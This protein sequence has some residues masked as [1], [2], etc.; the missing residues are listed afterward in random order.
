MFRSIWS[1]SLR[2]YRVT[3]LAWGLGLGVLMAAGLAEATPTVIAAFANLATLF[4]FLGDPYAIQTPEGFIT[5]RWM[6]AFL[7]LLLSF[8]PI[9]VGARL[10]RGEEERGTLD[11]LLATPQTRTRLLLSK[12]GALASALILIAV[13]FALG[14]VAGEAR[15]G[16][17]HIAMLRALLAGL[18]LGLLAFFF[19]MVALLLSQLTISRGVAA[20]WTSGLLLLTLLLDSTG[21]LVNGSWVQYLSPFYYYNLNRPLIPSFPDQPVAVLLLLGLSLLCLGIS[22]VLFTRRDIG[23]A[24]FSWQRKQAFN[25]QQALHSLGRAERAFS[26]RNVSLHTLSE[27]GWP[28]FWWLFGVVVLCVYCLLLALYIQQPFDKLVQETPLLQ[29]LL[30]DTPTNTNTA[31]LGTF[32]F[33]FMPA[34]VAIFALVLALKWSEDLENGRLELIFSTPQSRIRVLLERFGANALVLL[35]APVLTWLAITIGAQLAHLSVDQGRALAASFNMLPMALITISLVYALAG[36]IRYNALLG[37]LVAY[38]VLSFV[39]ELLEG[40]IQFPAWLMSL[41]IF[42]LYGNPVFL[43]MNWNNFLGMTAVAA[44]LLLLGLVQFRSADIKLG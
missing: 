24:A 10:V 15:L 5:F 4:R 17:G 42:H 9:L 41:S 23:R 16:G 27:Q 34:L 36:R 38:L 14:T 25:N 1:K 7:P 40:M 43:G 20:G 35:P 26:T 6:G 29:Q 11:V 21:R 18:N 32:L 8:W 2:D 28:A 44:I 31:L 39:E 33:T 37:I 22:L 13:L 30:F 19:G 12:V 3:I